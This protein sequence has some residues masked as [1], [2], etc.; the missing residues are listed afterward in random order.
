MRSLFLILMKPRSIALIRPHI[1]VPFH[2]ELAQRISTIDDQEREISVRL[3]VVIALSCS[4]SHSLTG[5]KLFFML[6]LLVAERGEGTGAECCEGTAEGSEGTA[7]GG[8][9][10]AAK[11]AVFR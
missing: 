8:E 7:E 1:V 6:I 11:G 5:N 4:V 9:G 10:T 2:A 3:N